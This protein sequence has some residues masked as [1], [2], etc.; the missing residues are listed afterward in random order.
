MTESI[1][2]VLLGESGTGKTSIIAQFT[3]GEFDPNVVTSISAQFISKLMYISEYDKTIK[4]DIWD[5]AG[6]EKF[7]SLAQI[8]YK[9]AKAIIFVYDITDKKS[10]DELVNYWYP[11]VKEN[12]S[13][14][15]ILGLAGNKDDL[16]E[17]EQVTIEEAKEFADKIGAIYKKTSALN[18][19]NIQI[20]FECIS[21]KYIDSNYDYQAKD[22]E[23]KSKSNFIKNN[24]KN[25][26]KKTDNSKLKLDNEIRIK[27][28]QFC[29]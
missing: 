7:R 20:M 21:K 25:I 11:K 27:P 15:I 14:D 16:Y 13:S 23:V 8:F 18:N 10:F 2:I 12:C 6:Q 17:N 19:T 22:N 28:K 4:F 24:E 29:C 3:R 26:E 9:D 5:T 1:K